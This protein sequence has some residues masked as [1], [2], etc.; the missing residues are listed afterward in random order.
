M[1]EGANQLY[2]QYK[3]ELIE[4]KK[5]DKYSIRKK[6]DEKPDDKDKKPEEKKEDSK[7]AGKKPVMKPFLPEVKMAYLEKHLN[8]ARISLAQS[9]GIINPRYKDCYNLPDDDKNREECMNPF[10]A[11]EK[12]KTK[13]NI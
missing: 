1:M 5:K 4:L 6:G 7:D 3:T 8:D 9:E 13:N 10:S 11:V 12:E 2:V